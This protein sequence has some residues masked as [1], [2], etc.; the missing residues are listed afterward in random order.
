MLGTLGIINIF[1]DNSSLDLFHVEQLN[2]AGMGFV[3]FFFWKM[4]SIKSE[5]VKGRGRSPIRRSATLDG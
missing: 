3:P 4:V 5:A 2:G 1:V